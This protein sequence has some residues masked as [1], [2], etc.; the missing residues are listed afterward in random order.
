MDDKEIEVNGKTFEKIY[1][2]NVIKMCE[3]CFS[4]LDI[5][6]M[7]FCN[8]FWFYGLK[9]KELNKLLDHLDD[10]ENILTGY[11]GDLNRIKDDNNG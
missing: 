11:Y 2:E 7:N 8:F 1:L 4:N 10:M 5:F 3:K 9:K 6:R